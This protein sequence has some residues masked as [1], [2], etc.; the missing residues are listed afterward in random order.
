MVPLSR[1]Y[2]FCASHRLHSPAMTGERN[3]ETYGK[4]INPCGHGHNYHGH[5]YEVEITVRAMLGNCRTNKETRR[6]PFPRPR[7]VSSCEDRV[8]PL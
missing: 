7:K 5:N 8:R 1:R 3:R 6:V 4:R 2:A